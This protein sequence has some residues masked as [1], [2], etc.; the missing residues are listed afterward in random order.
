MAENYPFPG[1]NKVFSDPHGER[2]D[3]WTFFNGMT[4]FSRWKLSPEE[5]AE[6]NRTGEVCLA[7]LLGRNVPMPYTFVGSEKNI[8]VAT[9]DIIGRPFPK[10]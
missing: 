4:V 7:Q 8:R 6:I 10:I 3:I 2:P 5:L 1:A 9:M